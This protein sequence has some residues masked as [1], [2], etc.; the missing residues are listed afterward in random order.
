MDPPHPLGHS[1][2]SFTYDTYVHPMS[3]EK[4]RAADLMGTFATKKPIP[5]NL[6][7]NL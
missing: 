5:G 1:K 4:D 7:G 6:P 3:A 2:T